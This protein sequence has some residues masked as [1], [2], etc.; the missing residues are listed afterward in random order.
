MIP[1]ETLI[2]RY[3]ELEIRLHAEIGRIS[4][5]LCA[6]CKT[7]CCHSRYCVGVTESAWLRAVAESIGT[8]IPPGEAKEG[9]LSFL[10]LRGCT[11]PAGRPMECTWYICDDINLA[12]PDPLKRFVYQVFSNIL[13]YVVSRATTDYD[14]IEIA[15]LETLTVRQREKIDERITTAHKCMDI[16]LELLKNRHEPVPL[17]DTAGKILFLTRTFPYASGSVRFQGEQIPVSAARRK[18]GARA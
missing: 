18:A 9:E 8:S 11:L 10:S 3:A 15:D 4:G 12:M 14:L 1:I 17:E 5:S 6:V 7:I 13:G 2:Q 16:G